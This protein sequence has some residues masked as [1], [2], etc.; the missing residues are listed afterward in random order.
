M[1]FFKLVWVWVWGGGVLDWV[2][3]TVCVSGGFDWVLLYVSVG[4]LIRFYCMC[5]WGVV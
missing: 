5:Q 1:G 4:D 2:L 3:C